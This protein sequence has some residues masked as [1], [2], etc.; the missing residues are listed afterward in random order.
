MVGSGPTAVPITSVEGAVG[1]NGIRRKLHRLGPLNGCDGKVGAG[2]EGRDINISTK[3]D[4]V[5][6]VEQM[7]G[8]EAVDTFGKVRATGIW[9]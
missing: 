1:R 6:G 5:A 7:G 9:W 4:A 8:N 2:D 3:G